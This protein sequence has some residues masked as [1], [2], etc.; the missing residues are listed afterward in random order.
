MKSRERSVAAVNS[1]SGLQPV[2]QVRFAEI[3]LPG[4][5]RP[6]G[7]AGFRINHFCLIPCLPFDL[8]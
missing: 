1:V 5:V 8:R 6:S 4:I 2:D 7:A 3:D